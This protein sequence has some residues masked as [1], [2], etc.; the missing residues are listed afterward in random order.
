[1]NEQIFLM[2]GIKKYV[3]ENEIIVDGIISSQ[4]FGNG[5]NNRYNKINPKYIYLG[6][7]IIL[8]N[9]SFKIFGIGLK[10]ILKRQHYYLSKHHLKT[11]FCL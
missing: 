11:F 6:F 4:I 5:S 8:R 2:E 1:M 7:R 9:F 10:Y 3:F